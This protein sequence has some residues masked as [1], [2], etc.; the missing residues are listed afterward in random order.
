MAE[1]PPTSPCARQAWSGWKWGCLIA[2]ALGAMAALGAGACYLLGA[3]LFERNVGMAGISAIAWL[4]NVADGRLDGDALFTV[5]GRP[6]AERLARKIDAQ[7][8]S[9]AGFEPDTW[10]A[11]TRADESAGTAEVRL[12]VKGTKGEATCIMHLR[13]SPQ[14][15]R[16]WQVEDVTFA[17]P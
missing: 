6:E 15:P 8:G 10:Q 17:A 13:L 16:L 12:P 11:R 1:Q 5:G 4:G 7:V 14:T 9:I 3:R 2:A